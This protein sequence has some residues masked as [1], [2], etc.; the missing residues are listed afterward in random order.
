MLELADLADGL[1]MARF[2]S[3]DLPVEI[4]PD[5]SP[6][7]AADREVEE[8]LRRRISQARPGQAVVG[9]EMGDGGCRAGASTRWIL[10]PI[11]ATRNYLRGVPVWAT[12][13]ALE[14]DGRVVAGAVSAPALGRRWWACRGKG[15]W[16]DGVQI[17]VS[18]VDDLARAYLSFDD[19]DGFEEA[20]APGVDRFVS[21]S[22]RC[23]RAR[24]LGD[25]WSHVLVAEGAVDVAVEPQVELWDMA[26]V[27]VIVEEAGGR[28][29]DLAGR[30]RPD[31]GSGVSTNGVL[32]D[33]V[34]AALAPGGAG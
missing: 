16:A 15:A 32:H 33:A 2:R 14:R 28:F 30:A 22:R 31:G 25:F 34:L 20:G 8:A 5:G 24:G 7:T 13:I 27:Q 6:V 12:L 10:D 3:P 11:D 4:K 18:G 1:S 19:V 9:E 17:H 21:L 23:E 26:A 29:S